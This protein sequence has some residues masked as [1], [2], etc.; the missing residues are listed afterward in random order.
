M[1]PVLLEERIAHTARAKEEYGT[2]IPWLAD[3]MANDLK[4]AFGDKNNS[5]FVI[6]PDGTVLLARNWSDPDQLRRDL[7]RLVGKAEKTTEPVRRQNQTS[8]PKPDEKLIARGVVPRVERPEGSE[9]LRVTTHPGDNGEPLYLK[10]RAEASAALRT[11]GKGPLFIGLHLDPIHHV[12]WNNLAPPLQYKI[13]APDEVAVT[14][15]SGEA[16]QVTDV[17]ADADPREFLVEV[18]RASLEHPIDLTVDYYACDDQDEWCK[19]LTQRFTITWETD[20]DGGRV[21]SGNRNRR[22]ARKSRLPESGGPTPSRILARYDANGDEKISR[23]E[24]SGPMAR[25][26]NGMD[27]DANGW[28]TKEEL[29][30]S[31]EKRRRR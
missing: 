24:A 30:S 14:P 27:A 7:E 6:S 15:S 21:Q 8:P 9:P 13:A 19:A 28:V 22:G 23:D 5:E 29:S 2:E 17:E 11:V 4:H 16:I 31:L 20:P 1:Q 18:D 3:S 26:F 10:L 25:R 12:H